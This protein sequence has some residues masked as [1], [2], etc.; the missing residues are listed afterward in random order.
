MSQR[1]ALEQDVIDYVN[2]VIEI[3]ERNLELQKII[4][5][6]L[7]EMLHRVDEQELEGQNLT[8]S[9]FGVNNQAV[10]FMK[11]DEVQPRLKRSCAN[12]SSGLE[13]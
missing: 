10:D 7:Y 13:I 6:L 2:T 9:S 12:N 3:F 1:T 5:D 11:V 8:L 4:S